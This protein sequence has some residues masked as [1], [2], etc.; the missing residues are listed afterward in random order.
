MAIK[1]LLVEDHTLIRTS[2]RAL[3]ERQPDIKVVGETAN[4]REAVEMASDLSPDIVLMDVVLRGSEVT[5]MQATQKIMESNADA[6]VVALSVMEDLTYVKRM[7]SA[8]ACGYLFKGCTEDELVAAIHT[9]LTG[10]TY[11]SEDA[12][13]VVQEDY[14]SAVQNQDGSRKSK[15]TAREV[16]ILQ[17]VASGEPSKSIA[18]DLNISRKTVD[19]HRHKIMEKLNIWSVAELTQYAMHEGI[20]T[21]DE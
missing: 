14:V 12:L 18:V 6:K 11:F 21:D 20:I 4:G 15:L 5:G 7:L 13:R 16:E 3:L 10:K 8:G 17:R 1:V 19:A 9:V 2:L